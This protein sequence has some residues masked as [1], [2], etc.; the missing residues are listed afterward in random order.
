MKK[1]DFPA[2]LVGYRIDVVHDRIV[3]FEDVPVLFNDA[4]LERRMATY[5]SLEETAAVEHPNLRLA[6]PLSC[7]RLCQD[8]A[9]DQLSGHLC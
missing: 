8:P 7:F 5:R 1:V 3:L 6:A 2:K 9:K 4:E